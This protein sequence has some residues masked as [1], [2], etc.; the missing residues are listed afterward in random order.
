MWYRI[1]E[2]DPVGWDN[3]NAIL[4]MGGIHY[5]TLMRQNQIDTFIRKFIINFTEDDLIIA[6]LKFG[7]GVSIDDI[8]SHEIPF[9]QSHGYLK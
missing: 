9:L 8:P 2:F 1:I 3:T 7:A 4:A 6:K 5:C